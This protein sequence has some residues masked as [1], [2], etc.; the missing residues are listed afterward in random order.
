[1][2]WLLFGF[3]AL[4]I[5]T[6]GVRLARYGDVI[7]TQSGLGGSW[8]GLILLAATTSL[9]ELFTGIGSTAL[10]PAP[11][12]AVGDVLGSC[13]F[14]L[15]IL[16][17]MDALSR[18]RLSSQAHRGHVMA[19]GQGLL[20]VGTAGMALAAPGQWPRL[21]WV[22]LYSPVIAVAYLLAARTTFRLERERMGEQRE[23]VAATLEHEVPTLRVALVR[24]AGA[25]VFVVAGALALPDLATRL[26]EETGLGQAMI[27]GLL[28]AFT[29]SLP[30]I[31]V[32]VT[33]VRMGALDL[34]IAS[35]LGSN[36]FN[37]LILA[38]DDAFYRQG[39]LLA[40][41]DRGHL[42]VL[43]AILVMYGIFLVGLTQQVTAKR[44]FVA[45]DTA[46]IAAVYVGATWLAYF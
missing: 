35:I 45:W 14:N 22:G 34:G 31:V 10:T 26:A 18:T 15:L 9:P 16:S 38:I 7:G 36:I 8:I 4:V 25:A 5:V 3:T 12:I 1:M 28:V 29:T 20:L 37:L 32:A 40:E 27:G 17:L 19:I 23:A 39:P 6:A 24:Y 30:E 41:V 11:D 46:A 13:M 21:G 44:F 33:A 2:T 42:T 43:V